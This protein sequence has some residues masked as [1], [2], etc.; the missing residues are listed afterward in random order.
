MVPDLSTVNNGQSEMPMGTYLYV[1]PC[2]I[3]RACG[4]GK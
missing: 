4:I 1:G 3:G 2:P